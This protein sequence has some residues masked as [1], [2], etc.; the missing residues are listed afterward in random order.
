MSSTPVVGSR[1]EAEAAHRRTGG[2][3]EGGRGEAG[4]EVRRLR[5]L[6]RPPTHLPP[7]TNMHTPMHT[8]LHTHSSM[9]KEEAGAELAQECARLH[10]QY[11]RLMNARTLFTHTSTHQSHPGA[12]H[13]RWRRR[14]RLWR[15]SRRSIP[16]PRLHLHSQ[17]PP[18][19]PF[20][21]PKNAYSHTH[22][23]EG[24]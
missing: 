11:W 19:H 17:H 18:T 10:A 8:F 9:A 1:G 7:H 14:R 3:E 23:E 12:H 15:S 6:L 16:A 20:T 4:R 5:D 21:S 13:H 22:R 2:E 24:V